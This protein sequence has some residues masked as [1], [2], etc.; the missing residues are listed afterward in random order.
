MGNCCSTKT[1][2]YKENSYEQ[3]LAAIEKIINVNVV[4][5]T[6]KTITVSIPTSAT[7]RELKNAI[8]E[9]VHSTNTTLLFDGRILHPNLKLSD[10]YNIRTGSTIHIKQVFKLFIKTSSDNTIKLDG[11]GLNDTIQ[12]VKQCIQDKKG[13]SQAQQR[14][15][16]DGQELKDYKTLF[17]YHIQSQSTLE[18]ILKLGQYKHDQ[19]TIFIKYCNS[20]R[21]DGIDWPSIPL[22]TN[23]FNTILDVKYAIQDLLDSKEN[24]PPDS[25]RLS[26]RG[27]DLDCVNWNLEDYDITEKSVIY[28]EKTCSEI[29]IL[30]QLPTTIKGVKVKEWQ[31]V[32]QLKFLIQKR[33]GIDNRA[34]K[35][36]FVD[37][38]LD[39]DL[40][41]ES[42]GIQTGSRIKVS[43]I[44]SREKYDCF[45]IF[46]KT[47]TGKTITLDVAENDT[48]EN[49][50]AKIQDKEGIP[51]QQ[52]RLIFAGKTL[53]DRKMLFEYNIQKE[54]TFHLVL[55][56]GG[57]VWGTSKRSME[58]ANM[59]RVKQIKINL[60][61]FTGLIHLCVQYGDEII[62]DE[63]CDI[64]YEYSKCIGGNRNS[65]EDWGQLHKAV[66]NND[67]E[68]VEKTLKEGH[69][70]DQWN[71]LATPLYVAVSGHYG[72]LNLAMV[73]ILLLNGARRGIRAFVK[74][75]ANGN[76]KLLDLLKPCI[77]QDPLVKDVH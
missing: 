20:E 50:K 22:L 74:I 19:M 77:D 34:Q 60:E 8:D 38:E 61:E 3:P 4:T 56:L 43:E 32:L 63:I 36:I 67:I 72:N 66:E 41:L 13:I 39:E 12:R 14:L 54:C 42:Y 51:P 18:L 5:L 2:N 47:L 24:I 7:L 70:V 49:V 11:F 75:Y 55:N 69:Y 46:V 65:R 71:H 73:E 28:V 44:C 30:L 64:L 48:I 33:E 29:V 37:K 23:K 31:T 40:T 35:L 6:G 62:P 1:P 16:F 26:V 57:R 45:Q 21:I 53:K 52:Q 17:D 58:Y 68:M 25:Q 9:C 59:D 10:H 76:D 27:N 15:F